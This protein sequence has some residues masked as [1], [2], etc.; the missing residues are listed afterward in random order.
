MMKKQE[1]Q[2]KRMT[3]VFSSAV[4]LLLVPFLFVMAFQFVGTILFP[5]F[6][7]IAM[8]LTG[9]YFV[10]ILSVL[11]LNPKKSASS[12]D[13]ST[14]IDHMEYAKPVQE[15]ILSGE[16]SLEN[17]VTEH[18]EDANEEEEPDSNPSTLQDAILEE[19]PLDQPVEILST[20][21]QI[22]SELLEKHRPVKITPRPHH[23]EVPIEPKKYCDSLLKYMT[24]QGLSLD[25]ANLRETFA[26]MATSKLIVIQKTN[27]L[28]A[29]RYLE[30]LTD[31]L[32]VHLWVDEIQKDLQ[33]YENLFLNDGTF[34][35][36]L[37]EATAHPH[38]IYI[39]ALEN[40]E[41]AQASTFFRR[42]VEFAKNP[43]IPLTIENQYNAIKAAIPSNLW[44]FMIPN[45]ENEVP[46][47]MNLA[48]AAVS[49]ELD[50]QLVSP[51][52]EVQENG[53]K[54][55]LETFENLLFDGYE[56]H[57]I[58]ESVWKN[59]DHVEDYFSQTQPF[60][61]DNRL[62]RQMERYTST[63]LMFGG[64]PNDALDRMLYAKLLHVLS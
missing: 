48:E 6:I 23:Y 2:H 9:F 19:L 38:R 17:R 20:E 32:G 25:Q 27:P 43:L 24:E 36:C 41:L 44:F 21:I 13:V 3:L 1:A 42:I 52:E 18:V 62:F 50:I 29:K 60:T 47:S 16:A 63:Y 37:K 4:L 33:Q 49:L 30:I 34:V 12:D 7:A 45:A 64:D 46:F 10:N 14:L 57:Y 51:K 28:L 8:V 39:M 22:T 11:K 59:L 15:T 55:S 40:V 26:S 35:K 53:V 56:Q 31:Y 54:L 61:I 58:E 5:I